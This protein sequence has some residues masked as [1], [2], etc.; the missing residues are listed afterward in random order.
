M[1]S[2]DL[3]SG[4]LLLHVA[5]SCPEKIVALIGVTIA[6]DGMETLSNAFIIFL[7]SFSFFFKMH[8]FRERACT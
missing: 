4:W 2:L 1:F 5:I 8:L 3:D 7:K 6:I